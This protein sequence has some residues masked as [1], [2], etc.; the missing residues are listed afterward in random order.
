MYHCVVCITVLSMTVSGQ[1][2]SSATTMFN[3]V[4][5]WLLDAKFVEICVKTHDNFPMT[6][7]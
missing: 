1:L 4:G 2:R 5:Q 7:K 3:F 6:L